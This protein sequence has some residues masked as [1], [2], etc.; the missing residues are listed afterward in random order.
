MA[1]FLFVLR[2]SLKSLLQ[3][4]LLVDHLQL[5]VQLGS[6]VVVGHPRLDAADPLQQLLGGLRVVPKAVLLG[7][8]FFFFDFLFFGIY[9]KDTSLAHRASFEPL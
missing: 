7:Y 5:V 4:G 2:V 9:V 1:N 6:F 3:D 8:L